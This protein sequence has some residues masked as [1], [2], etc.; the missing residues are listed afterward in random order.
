MPHGAAD[1]FSR[2]AGA[3]QQYTKSKHCLEHTL[4]AVSNDNFQSG[5]EPM[6]HVSLMLSLQQPGLCTP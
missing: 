2:T 6:S 4:E 1:G 3:E 5:R